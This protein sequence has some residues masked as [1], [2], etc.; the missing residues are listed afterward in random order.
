[1]SIPQDPTEDEFDAREAEPD[2]REIVLDDERVVDPVGGEK[3]PVLDD[4]REVVL[5]DDEDEEIEDAYPTSATPREE[6]ELRAQLEREL[7]FD[8]F[9][10]GMQG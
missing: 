3:E 7:R 4:E 9:E 2:D 5:D 1:M 10:Q 8:G 6:I